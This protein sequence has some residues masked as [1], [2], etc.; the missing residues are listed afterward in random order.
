MVPGIRPPHT[1]PLWQQGRLGAAPSAS[2]PCLDSLHRHPVWTPSAT[3]TSQ[4]KI[5]NK[6]EAVQHNK[7]TECLEIHPTPTGHGPT[8]RTPSSQQSWPGAQGRRSQ[9][10]PH[11]PERTT[12][13]WLRPPRSP[14]GRRRG[15]TAASGQKAPIFSP[16]EIS[17]EKLSVCILPSFHPPVVAPFIFP[18]PAGLFQG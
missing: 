12:I 6:L 13:P 18:F 17:T 3:N 14:G 7:P 15:A 11:V 1:V 5:L 10:V 2:F 9:M 8:R 16:I 4:G